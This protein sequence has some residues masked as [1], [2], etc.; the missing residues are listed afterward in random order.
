MVNVGGC[1]K[2]AWTGRRKALIGSW[3]QHNELVADF[4]L[5]A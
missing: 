1:K 4:V 2:S 5:T 3:L